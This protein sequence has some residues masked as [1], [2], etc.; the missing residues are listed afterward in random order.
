[1][2]A[3]SFL[4]KVFPLIWSVFQGKVFQSLKDKGISVL[5]AEWVVLAFS[6]EHSDDMSFNSPAFSIVPAHSTM[7]CI[8][9]NLASLFYC[10]IQISILSSE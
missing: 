6:A 2:G 8:A 9:P 7:P 3:G 4:V 10:R 1:M 5:K